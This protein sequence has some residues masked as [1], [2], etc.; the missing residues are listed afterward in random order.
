MRPELKQSKVRAE[1]LART[2]V[3]YLRQ[4]SM[5]QV[6][7]N[8]ESQRLQYALEDRAR[9]LGW[10]NVEVIDSDLGMSAGFAARQRPGFEKVIS[11]VALGQVGI[12]LSR[13]LSRLSRTD[14]DWCRLLELCQLY[15]TLIGDED[16]IYDL[17]QLDDQL[18]LG[19]KGTLSVVELKTLK[20]RMDSGRR[21]K[22]RRGALRVHLAPG[23][24][25]DVDGGIVKDPDLRVQEAIKLV[26]DRF[27]AIGSVRRLHQAIVAEGMEF[28]VRPCRGKRMIQWSVPKLLWVMGVLKNP[29]YA[30][31]YVYGRRPIET[32]V[33]EGRLQK[34][35]A[36]LRSPED[37][38]VFISDHHDGYIDWA[39]FKENQRMIGESRPRK[40]DD[41]SRTAA[42]DGAA[43]LVGLLRCGHCGRK[44]HVHYWTAGKAPRYSCKG[45]YDQAGDYC[46]VFSGAPVERAVVEQVL[47][48]IT[49]MGVDASTLAIDGLKQRR[50][51]QLSSLKRRLEQ[52]EYEA[53]R[54]FEQYDEVD[55]RNRLVAGELERRWNAKLEECAAVRAELARQSEEQ[56]EIDA[57]TIDRIRE[58]GA[59]FDAVWHDPACT[60]LHKKK[61]LRAVLTEIIVTRSEN[62]IAL[63]LHWSGGVHTKVVVHAPGRAH[64]RTSED[65]LAIVRALAPSYDDKCIAAILNRHGMRTGAGKRWTIIRVATVRRNHSIAGGV[66]NPPEGTLTLKG[67]ATKYGVT[68][69]AIERLVE[70]GLVKNRQKILFAPFE[71]SEADLTSD[72]V[73]A[74]LRGYKKTG[75]VNV[76]GH[77]TKKQGHLFEEIQG[78]DH[79]RHRR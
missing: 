72:R 4:S 69:H 26:F 64:R 19:I 37:A 50:N 57:S 9:S 1:H 13:E 79:D 61:I 38:E 48:V 35:H 14:R 47:Q 78:D 51:E 76:E 21:A 75:R 18:V 41:E 71:L 68:I 5:K 24:V 74:V 31:A 70:A 12:V 11:M 62:E 39:T 8:L 2:A 34:R 52:L 23:Y 59:R 30:G 65:A 7:E 22:A 56:R 28:P 16:Q 55:P 46:V 10:K 17:Q 43:L 27:R 32:I 42:R 45:D 73:Q 67:A 58:L 77:A 3:V 33:T 60:P 36:A 49:P 6:R 66:S 25:F 44:F 54:A 63:V 29:I 40:A 53:T 20:A 15:E